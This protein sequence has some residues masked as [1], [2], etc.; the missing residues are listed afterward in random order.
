M[1]NILLTAF[2][3][4]SLN[5]SSNEIDPID[6]LKDFV[7]VD[8]INPPGNEINAVKFYAEIFDQYGISY[9]VAESAPGRGNIW[10]RI[11]GGDQPALMLLQHT[12]VVPAD[13]EY[14]KTDPMLGTIKDGYLYGRGVIDMK[15]LGIAHL[16]AFL[17]A[18]KNQEKLTRDIVFMATADEEAGDFL[19]QAGC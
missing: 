4:C 1:K 19:E 5:I 18:F 8:T 16:V 9:E 7:A 13:K 6:L 15:G 14:W 17:S 11:E 12:D 10:A 2:V 3:C